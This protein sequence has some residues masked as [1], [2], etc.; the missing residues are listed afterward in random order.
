MLYGPVVLVEEDRFFLGAK[1]HSNNT[2]ELTGFA[3]A[4][5]EARRIVRHCIGVQRRVPIFEFH[6]DSSYVIDV[7]AGQ[8][9]PSENGEL[10]FMAKQLY[11]DLTSFYTKTT[12]LPAPEI[13]KVKAHSGVEENEMA[14]RLAKMGA[15]GRVSRQAGRYAEDNNE[16]ADVRLQKPLV[17]ME[18]REA[19]IAADWL[20]PQLLFSH[21]SC[22]ASSA[23][24]PSSPPSPSSV[25]NGDMCIC[26]SDILELPWDQLP[27]ISTKGPIIK[28]I[29]PGAV[30]MVRATVKKVIDNLHEQVLASPVGQGSEMS[31]KKVLLVWAA[32]FL[33]PKEEKALTNKES[34]TRRCRAL[35][36]DDWSFFM[37]DAYEDKFGRI[38]RSTDV[39]PSPLTDP[40]E[41]SRRWKR[42]NI[43][44]SQ[45]EYGRAFNVMVSKAAP[46]DPTEGVAEN[47]ASKF[48]DRRAPID[49]EWV[50]IVAQE[51]GKDSNNGVHLID[52]TAERIRHCI[53]SA[54]RGTAP[55]VDGCSYDTLRHLITCRRA[56]GDLREDIDKFLE[57]LAFLVSHTFVNPHN[58]PR[59]VSH[60]LASS[61]LVALQEFVNGKP[62]FR[63]IAMGVIFSKIGEKVIDATFDRKIIADLFGDVQYGCG[64]PM[65]QDKLIHL[66]RVAMEMYPELDISI[67]DKSNAIQNMPRAQMLKAVAEV[68]KPAVFPLYRFLEGETAAVFK[69]RDDVVE[70]SKK[71]GVPQGGVLS[72]KLYNL[73]GIEENKK[74]NEVCRSSRG[75]FSGSY[76]DD[77]ID[78]SS[79]ANI[80]SILRWDSIEKLNMEKHLILLGRRGS[81]QQARADRERYSVEHGIPLANI[82]AHPEDV[83]LPDGLSAEAPFDFVAA[84][85]VRRAAELKYGR[86]TL[87]V[88]V[89]EPAFVLASLEKAW[90]D[91][92]TEFE[93]VMKIPDKQTLLLFAR[94]VMMSKINHFMRGVPPSLLKDFLKKFELVQRRVWE[95]ICGIPHI[96]FTGGS[97]R[98]AEEYGV[99]FDIAKMGTKYG[100]GLGNVADTQD[101]AYV[102]SF[103]AAIP[104]LKRTLPDF[105]AVLDYELAKQRALQEGL[106]YEGD[107]PGRAS[108]AVSEFVSAVLRLECVSEKKVSMESLLDRCKEGDKGI[109]GLQ[110]SLSHYAKEK[111]VECVR[112]YLRQHPD[113]RLLV[114]FTGGEGVRESAWVTALLTDV[115]GRMSS[116]LFS[117]AC[118]RRC[119]LRQ[120]LDVL[121]RGAKCVCKKHPEVDAYGF[122]LQ[123]CKFC[124][125]FTIETHDTIKRLMHQF[126]KWGGMNSTM[127]PSGLFVVSSL[128]ASASA[129]VVPPPDASVASA[130]PATSGRAGTQEEEEGKEEEGQEVTGG[131]DPSSSSSASSSFSP[132]EVD[133]DDAVSVASSCVDNKRVDLLVRVPGQLDQIYD[134]QITNAAQEKFKFQGDKAVDCALYAKETEKRKKYG[135]SA[136]AANFKFYPLILEVGGRMGDTFRFIYNSVLE[137]V[138]SETEIPVS[139]LDRFWSVR[140]SVALQGSVS[141]QVLTRAGH[142]RK[143][144]FGGRPDLHNEINDDILRQKERCEFEGGSHLQEA[145]RS[146]V[147]VQQHP[148]EALVP[149]CSSV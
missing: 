116:D 84:D 9:V 83:C 100:L 75:G 44:A 22:P 32:L 55:G 131:Y 48:P 93:I 79:M 2:G 35:L 13:K 104:V 29:P 60:F 115:G 51:T 105:E 109:R 97:D 137:K 67:S 8:S 15:E 89:G 26:V 143:A 45:G 65:G 54:P 53:L 73:G 99:S 98:E 123:M 58:V 147:A 41:H 16:N 128:M 21:S 86:K 106:S 20:N 68:N 114:Q 37:L 136:E 1:K 57:S 122:H 149:G 78:A 140:L 90:E 117:C 36:A 64:T 66:T 138:S 10:V 28:N 130:A 127:E 81:L 17:P 101:A 59:C 52:V 71:E 72:P 80:D 76:F 124:N 70:I 43:L 103:C 145:R 19:A 38:P 121:P 14:D 49:E 125:V 31:Y 87:G 56:R 135:Q 110:R 27:R 47:L 129:A 139:L 144:F 118:R 91:L 61:L 95:S 102:A 33:K 146:F 85:E 3:E 5:I 25:S 94:F 40:D 30:A 6:L 69:T 7:M 4:L 148:R 113:P 112:A 12:S 62:K 133:I 24:S 134:V 111:R 63:P 126:F 42:A 120:P 46:V 82:L 142:V 74:H 108:L 39:P 107:Y 11:R 88:P 18:R 50:K 23:S 96:E 92:Q 119:L 77:K 141:R 132:P 34:I